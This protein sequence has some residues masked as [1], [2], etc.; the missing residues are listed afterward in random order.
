LITKKSKI[1]LTGH[2]G[3]VGSSVYRKLKLN[4]YKNILISNKKKLDLRNQNN[5]NKFIKKNKPNCIIIAAGKVGGIV[6]NSSYPGDFIYD[7]V[8]I[9]TNLINSAYKNNVKNL[10]YLGSSCVYP[11]NIKRK[12]KET[13]LLKYYLEKTNEAYAIAKI[14][15]IKLCEYYNKQYNLN[16][17]S[18]MPSNIYGPNDNYDLKNSH[19]I[20][21][22]IK[23]IHIAKKRNKKNIILWGNGK[24]KREILYVDDLADAVLFFLKKKTK[25]SL[26]NIGTGKDMTIEKYAY[27]IMEILEYKTNIIFDKSKPN[28][29]YRKVLDVSLAKKYGWESSEDLR[30]GLIKTY[31]AFIK[32]LK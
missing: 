21:A 4:G 29:T 6:A 14:T 18:L 13:D 24:S 25:H 7:N 2:L 26:I 1:F 22:L 10:I 15:G 30:S 23:K 16:Y 20:P 11:S 12:I 32:K 3:L 17:L 9:A 31:D 8:M 27:K 19:F 5:V 28:G